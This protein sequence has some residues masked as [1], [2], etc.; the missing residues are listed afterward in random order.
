MTLQIALSTALLVSAGLFTQSLR[1]VSRV[2]LGLDVDS[3]VTFAIAPVNNGYEPSESMALFIRAEEE[4]SALP[5]VESVTAGLVPLI[6]GSNWGS[7]LTVEG[8]DAGPDTDTNSRFNSVGPGYFHTVGIPLLAGREFTASDITDRPKVAIVNETFVEKFG[9]GR[10]AIGKRFARSTGDAAELDTE[11]VG[12]VKDAKYSSVKDEIPPLFFTP[13]R[14]DNEFGFINFYVR[15]GMDPSALMP[16]LR[17]VMRGLD[18]NL[19]VEE[20]K[21]MP[22]QIRENVFLDRFLTTLSAAFAILAT[23]LAAVG[24]YGV[25]AYTVTQR[26]REFGVRM[27]LGANGR[28]VSGLV[29]R[30]LGKMAAIGGALGV[31]AAI[32]VGTVAQSQ[33]YDVK[34]WDPVV[35]VTSV[36]LL[37][38]IA[39]SAGLV[40]ARR[41]ATVDPMKV[42]RDE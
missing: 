25:L 9:L 42:L 39:L 24:L 12:V 38:L 33:L 30:Q 1:N 2:D 7:S 34:G 16:T 35:L 13:Y 29:M 17:E 31:I 37:T 20:M 15:T 14:Q 3:L 40:P 19:P 8:F 10:D 21:T 5:G 41:A 27:A 4:L 26:R 22:Q 23:I 28:T 32:G 6:A 18:P 36:V 11:I